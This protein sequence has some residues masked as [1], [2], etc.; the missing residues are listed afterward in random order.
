MPADL[1]S[2]LNPYQAPPLVDAEALGVSACA[3]DELCP[4]ELCPDELCPDELCP[5]ESSAEGAAL[6]ASLGAIA[7]WALLS[8]FDFGPWLFDRGAMVAGLSVAIVI[9]F[10]HRRRR[11]RLSRHSAFD[12]GSAFEAANSL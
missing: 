2:T 12:A 4:D 1:G 7:G 3:P 5:E 10:V 6:G 8:V 11:N 9:F